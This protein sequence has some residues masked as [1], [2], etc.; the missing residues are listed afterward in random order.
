M[1]KLVWFIADTPKTAL[2]NLK[3][4]LLQLYVIQR[5]LIFS[6]SRAEFCDDSSGDP[7]KGCQIKTLNTTHGVSNYG[8]LQKLGHFNFKIIKKKKKKSLSLRRNYCKIK[9]YQRS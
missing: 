7:L 1:P 8:F 3:R 2:G 5:K 9:V 6:A 4:L